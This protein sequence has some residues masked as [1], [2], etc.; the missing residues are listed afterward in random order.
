L[1]CRLLTIISLRN[2]DSFDLQSGLE[3]FTASILT[4]FSVFVSTGLLSFSS[5]LLVSDSFF[6]NSSKPFGFVSLRC[7]YSASDTY[8]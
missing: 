8:K 7:R 5:W 2:L 1:A 3:S 6:I 4:S